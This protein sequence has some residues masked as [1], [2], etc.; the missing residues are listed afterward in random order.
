MA[1]AKVTITLPEDE[2]RRIRELVHDGRAGSVSG[3]VA[4]VVSTALDETA[5]WAATLAEMLEETGGPMND[6]E[7]AWADTVLGG[8]PAQTRP[9]SAA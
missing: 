5:A 8:G 3:F 7:R 6:A 9:G 2:L 1:T 4:Q